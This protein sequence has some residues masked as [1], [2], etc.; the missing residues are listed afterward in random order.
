MQNTTQALMPMET[1]PTHPQGP[2]VWQKIQTY[3]LVSI[4]S[5]LIWLY[6]ESE[7]VKQQKPLQFT[8]EFVA[9]PGQPLL[10]GPAN[11]RQA[12]VGPPNQY[13]ALITVRC[14]T[15]QY[16]QLQQLQ[17]A[18][19]PITVTEQPDSRTQ[20]V[21]L[22]DQ[23]NDSPIGKLGVSLVDVQPTQIELSVERVVEV[24]MAVSTDTVV[25][26]GVQL[27]TVPTIEPTEATVSLPAGVVQ[28]LGEAKLEARLDRSS[29]GHLSEN[30]PHE[31][32]VPLTLPPVLREQIS[33]MTPVIRP[34]NATVTITIRKRTGTLSLTGVPILLTA[35]WAEMKR[36][37]VALE[38][39]QRVLSQDVEI[40]GPSDVIDQLRKGQLN[41]W[42][43][44]RLTV[45]DLESGIT[46]KQL[47]I[48]VPSGVQV[49]ST[50]PLVNF[51][52]TPLAAPPPSPNT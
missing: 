35:P 7:N 32:T 1:S 5:V 30:T 40:S 39:S 51:T 15:S 4:V 38:E 48:N 10:I 23:L 13:Q 25:P 27:A 34:G 2:S 16:A 20:A 43:E 41:V 52:I 14:A 26:P 6:S 24:R 44:L 21:F 45:D 18:P 29:V 22:R 50:A 9:P 28:T 36:F 3:I 12:K 42:A 37:S 49:E 46:S 47:R 33:F 11:R 17:A 31:L 19:I 8:L